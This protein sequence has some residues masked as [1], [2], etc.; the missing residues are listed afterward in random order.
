[1]IH[2][3]AAEMELPRKFSTKQQLLHRIQ[4]GIS[5]GDGDEYNP[6]SY[7]RYASRFTKEYKRR[8]YPEHDLLVSQDNEIGDDQEDRIAAGV[9]DRR[10]FIPEN[11]EQDY[12][13]IV[14]NRSR[15]I[16]V[17][18]GND[19]DTNDFGSG[20][21][22]SERGRSVYGTLDP[23]KVRQPEPKFGTTDYYKETWWNLN[24]I[25]WT[26]DSVLRHV[27]VGINGINVPWMYYGSLFTTFC[28]HNEDNYLYSINY[29]H[30]GAPKQWYGVPGT[31]KDAD[32][33]EKVFKSYLS[34]KMR[35]VPDLL[36]HITTQFS[37]RLLQNA[38]VPIYKLLQ[39]EGEFVVTFP[40]AFHGG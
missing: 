24:N 9:D 27:K 26:P 5:F 35:E 15:E 14:E 21:P 4:E 37:P 17:E 32:G 22:L 28:W 3:K 8:E 40:R 7:Q 36:H 19:V 13:D 6:G 10:R 33:L 12:W 2:I 23:E 16:A 38:H 30:Q 25:P 18:Y 11:L 31:K 1:M 29:H 34:M 39:H 20:F